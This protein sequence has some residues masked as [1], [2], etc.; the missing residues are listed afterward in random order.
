MEIV[1]GLIPEKWLKSNDVTSKGMYRTLYANKL[2]PLQGAW[3]ILESNC[4][5]FL[6]EFNTLMHYVLY[7]WSTFAM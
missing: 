7:L 2:G 5:G 3:E 1:H 6:M 4:E